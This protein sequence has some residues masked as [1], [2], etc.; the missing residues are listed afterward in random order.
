[1][2][3]ICSGRAFRTKAFS[4]V[5]RGE[6]SQGRSSVVKTQMKRVLRTAF[7]ATKMR[8]CRKKTSSGNALADRPSTTTTTYQC[9]KKSRKSERIGQN[10]FL[11]SVYVGSGRRLVR[12]LTF[13]MRRRPRC[14]ATAS[15]YSTKS[16][17]SK[18]KFSALSF[19]C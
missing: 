11:T 13:Q 14:R 16:P 18:C 10:S 7:I 9:S 8:T 15:K 17:L 5:H 19:F 3:S 2:S 12:S 6:D 4:R 1:M